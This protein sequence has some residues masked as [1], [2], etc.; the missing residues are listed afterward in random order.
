MTRRRSSTTTDVT[1]LAGRLV[2]VTVV[3]VVKA[4]VR[5][6][7]LLLLLAPVLLVVA[8]DGSAG[9][10]L[11]SAVL[12]IG[13]IVVAGF[14]GRWRYR[15]WLQR[16]A[17][18][19][20]AEQLQA[21]RAREIATYHA[22]N[23]RQFEEALAYLCARDG[24]SQTSVVGGSGDLGA[25]VVAVTPDGRRLVIQAK[26]YAQGNNVSGPDLQRFGGTCYAIHGAHVAVVITTGGFTRQ[27]REYAAKLGIRLIDNDSLAAWASG[28]GPAPWN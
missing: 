13:T 27:A 16:Q 18:R 28:T 5:M 6:P 19:A 24:C 1:V 23:A 3:A 25:D 4:V 9:D 21:L 8:A 10:P 17:D 11:R 7:S 14:F 22:M 26:R 12:I 15:R 2:T 20:A